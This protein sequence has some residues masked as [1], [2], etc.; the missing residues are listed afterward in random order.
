MF[1][2]S[3]VIVEKM[4]ETSTSSDEGFETVPPLRELISELQQGQG[5]GGGG[6]GGGPGGPGGGL[7]G[8]GGG[9][10][11]GPGGGPGGL[12]SFRGVG[13]GYL[14]S[15]DGRGVERFTGGEIQGSKQRVTPMEMEEDQT[16][17]T[18]GVPRGFNMGGGAFWQGEEPV[19]AEVIE[20]LDTQTPEPKGLADAR[21]NTHRRR[22][23]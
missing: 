1:P 22:G 9:G 21:R 3:E 17:S 23:K 8:L 14:D 15:R 2:P 12:G 7:G 4:E 16:T 19:M 10:L 20:L 5:P 11:G 6:L 18:Q 13:G